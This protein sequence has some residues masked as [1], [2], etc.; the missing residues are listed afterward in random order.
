M[1]DQVIL[2][3]KN[4]VH[5]EKFSFFVIFS[6]FLAKLVTSEK[7]IKNEEFQNRPNMTL[8]GLIIIDVL[9]YGLVVLAQLYLA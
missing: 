3:H 4:L 7:I 5:F 9:N 2:A 1:S 8:D 6:D